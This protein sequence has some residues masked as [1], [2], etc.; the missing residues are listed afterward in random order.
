AV[1]R[2]EIAD[3][4]H[5]LEAL[6]R[7]QR[8]PLSL[9]AHGADDRTR[10]G[11]LLRHLACPS[12]RRLRA[13]NQRA[14][15]LTHMMNTSSTRAAAQARAWSPG[16]GDSESSKI[17]SGTVWIACSGFQDVPVATRE[18]T[19]SIGAVSPAARAAART[20]AVITPPFACG[21]TMLSVVRQRGTPS[22]RLASRSDCGTSARTSIAERA[23][24]G[25]MMIASANEPARPLWPWP[26]T[27]T[28][29]TIDGMP[30]S[31]SSASEVRFFTRACAN[32]L[33]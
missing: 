14:V 2:I 26:R 30:F 16:S 12:L 9:D 11:V 25:S 3:L 6:A 17:A 1:D 19:R 10:H 13:E 31:M 15:R 21:R 8:L 27:K 20:V 23:M 33:R 18:F 22:P 28:P 29:S 32:S 7:R 4:E 24:S 5:G